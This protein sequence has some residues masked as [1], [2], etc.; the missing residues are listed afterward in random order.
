MEHQTSDG[1]NC[2]CGPTVYQ[3]PALEGTTSSVIVHLV[4]PGDTADVPGW[5]K[6]PME[7][8]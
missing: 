6:P 7:E 4:H 3:V 2:P 8:S 1:A 5:I